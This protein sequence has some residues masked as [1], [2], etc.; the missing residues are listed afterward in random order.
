MYYWVFLF[1][2]GLMS[3]LG[4]SLIIRK[5]PVNFKLLGAKYI[6]F[7]VYL[8][9]VAFNNNG[10][11]GVFYPHLFRIGSPLIYLFGPVYYFFI[12]ATIR[13]DIKF[14]A[15]HLLHLLPF[16]LHIIELTPFYRLS[17]E[18]KK[19]LNTIFVQSKLTTEWGYFTYRQHMIF[20]I[21]LLDCY[22]LLSMYVAWPFLYGKNRNSDIRSKKLLRWLKVDIP[23]KLILSL[24]S[25]FV[26][27]FYELLPDPF[28]VLQ[29]TFPPIIILPALLLLF[30]PEVS[31][32]E[33]FSIGI[34]DKLKVGQVTSERGNLPGNLA[35]DM[36]SGES[37]FLSE[38]NNV[39]QENYFKKDLDVPMLAKLMH[40]SERSLYRKAREVYGKSPALVLLDFRM[41]KVYSAIQNDQESTIAQVAEG[42][43][44]KSNGAFSANFSG[45]YGMLPSEFQKKCRSNSEIKS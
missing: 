26:L 5:I 38:M 16:L 15:V 40:L 12:L 44:L 18:E 20:K 1:L 13:H 34:F 43:G 3:L 33:H 39:L 32:S 24:S 36:G 10:Y 27:V 35:D 29:L 9:V 28:I 2:S 23:L 45:R 14:R 25:L 31:F 30:F 6:L 4:F 42:V 7:S 17:A 37:G 21:I 41:E 22:I 11:T 8:L 19:A